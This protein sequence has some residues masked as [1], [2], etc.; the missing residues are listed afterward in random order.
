[1]DMADIT[2]DIGAI[3][4]TVTVMVMVIHTM[5]IHTMAMVMAMAMAMAMAMEDIHTIVVEGVITA[6][7]I[8]TL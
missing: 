1:M 8:I 6:M 5:V 3:H 7:I 4:T 2:A